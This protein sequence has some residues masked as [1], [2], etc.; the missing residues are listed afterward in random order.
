MMFYNIRSQI[1]LTFKLFAVIVGGRLRRDSR[2]DDYD[3]PLLAV[4]TS[5]LGRPKAK[6]IE[7]SFQHSK[8]DHR[9]LNFLILEILN[10]TLKN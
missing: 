4:G 9:T 3:S 8:F 5:I 2:V 6:T 10:K 7:I 1:L